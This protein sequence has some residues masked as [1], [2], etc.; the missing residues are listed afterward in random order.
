MS[1]QPP[2]PPERWLYN[3]MCPSLYVCMYVCMYV[4][5]H[6]M[7]TTSPL[8]L[9]LRVSGEVIF[10]KLWVT[11]LHPV[12]SLVDQAVWCQLSA[13]V[14]ELKNNSLTW[15]ALYIVVYCTVY[16]TRMYNVQYSTVQCTVLYSTVEMATSCVTCSAPNKLHNT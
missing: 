1:F 9:P 4:S 13:P 7:K 8:T 3:R 15:T 10:I 5:A 2:V 16:S 11:W 6:P 12:L 14:M